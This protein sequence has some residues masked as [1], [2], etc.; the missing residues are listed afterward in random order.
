M[1]GSTK[2]TTGTQIFLFDAD[3]QEP[4]GEWDRVDTYIQFNGGTLDG[5]VRRITGYSPANGLLLAPTLAASIPSGASYALFKTFHPINSWNRAINETLLDMSPDRMI[6]SFA[7][8]AESFPSG[9]VPSML[10]QVPSAAV[11]D[12]RLIKIDRSMWTTMSAY[13]YKE[14]FQG[15]DYDLVHQDTGSG[16]MLFMRLRYTPSDGTNLRFHYERRLPGLTA[17]TD[18]TAEP[19][20][21]ILYGARYHIAIMEN[22]DKAQAIW[23]LRFREAVGRFPIDQDA[24]TLDRPRITVR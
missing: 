14:L 16:P 18:I 19:L 15:F 17:D 9:G 3:R 12:A 8:T 5:V 6:Q 22:D 10:L 21:A 7:T 20:D 2:T 4:K 23:Q 13:D 11:Q 1:G 24:R